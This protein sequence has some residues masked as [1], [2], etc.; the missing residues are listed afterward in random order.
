VPADSP[1]FSVTT[2]QVDD[3]LVVSAAGELDVVTSPRL[4]E[5]VS[6]AF[7]DSKRIVIDLTAVTFM[8][9]SALRVL[10]QSERDLSARSGELRVIV[11]PGRVHKVLQLTGML[12]V[13]SVHETLADAIGTGA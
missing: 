6:G 1:P 11:T 9:S 2:D 10:T 4:Q 8:D 7:L 5:V 3:W 12:D 13:L